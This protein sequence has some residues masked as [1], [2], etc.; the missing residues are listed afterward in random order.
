MNDAIKNLIDQFT[1][2]ADEIERAIAPTGCAVVASH[3]W[4]VVDDFGAMTFEL[5]PEGKKKRAVCNGH[6]SA[7]KVNR[8][9][10]ED[11]QRLARACDAR[12]VFWKDAAKEELDS[13]RAHIAKFNTL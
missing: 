9:T 11:A 1:T 2:R 5:T 10:S 7:H 12:A 3:N 8:F 4:I 6:G 13:L